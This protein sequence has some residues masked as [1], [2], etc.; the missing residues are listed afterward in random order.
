MIHTSSYWYCYSCYDAVPILHRH[1]SCGTSRSLDLLN[2]TEGKHSAETTSENVS[3]LLKR[4]QKTQ[5]CP[6]FINESIYEHVERELPFKI[7]QFPTVLRRSTLKQKR[8][9][10]KAH[11]KKRES[12]N[13]ESK[14]YSKISKKQIQRSSSGGRRGGRARPA[15]NVRGRLSTAKRGFARIIANMMSIMKN[16]NNKE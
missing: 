12:K 13:T 5:D 10:R 14:K 7:K 15:R 6:K 2:T 16:V 3:S 8:K 11:S 9:N 1:C 4:F